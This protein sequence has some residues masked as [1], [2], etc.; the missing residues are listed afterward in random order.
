M[1]RRSEMLSSNPPSDDDVWLCKRPSPDLAPPCLVSAFDEHA[2]DVTTTSDI[3]LGL[4]KH[5]SAFSLIL[6]V[7]VQCALSIGQLRHSLP[8]PQCCDQ[9]YCKQ[10][11]LWHRCPRRSSRGSTACSMYALPHDFARYRAHT[12]AGIPGPSAH[13]L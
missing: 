7:H 12:C 8:Q 11:A 3:E 5:V 2:Q 9:R 13:L 6:H 1:Q 4:K 10:A